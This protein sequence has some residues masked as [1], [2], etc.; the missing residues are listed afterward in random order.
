[1][2]F[3]KGF[4]LEIST[5]LYWFGF[6]RINPISSILDFWTEF[7]VFFFSCS[8]L[9][10]QWMPPM[11][12]W[13][14]GKASKHESLHCWTV[15]VLLAVLVNWK[16]GMWSMI[17]FLFWKNGSFVSFH[18]VNNLKGKPILLSKPWF[19][20]LCRCFSRYWQL[21]LCFNFAIDCKWINLSPLL[22]GW[23]RG[24]KHKLLRSVWLN[25][26]LQIYHVVEIWEPTWWH[27]L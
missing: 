2:P 26:S 1:M 7:F 16:F 11:M 5:L 20:C 19:P 6:I 14:I 3:M 23:G 21:T 27:H 17:V 12:F 24:R 9:L 18:L 10:G 15:L 8:Y 13:C 4:G 25:L 22:L